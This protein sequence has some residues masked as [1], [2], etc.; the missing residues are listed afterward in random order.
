MVAFRCNQTLRRRI[1]QTAASE[2]VVPESSTRLGDWYANVV[3]VRRQHVVLAVS[4][5]TLLPVLVR[6][7]PYQTLLPRFAIAADQVLRALQID[8]GKVVAEADAMRDMVVARL[9]GG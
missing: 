7:A 8:E 5:V 1:G 6:A 3:S 9:V 4:G 2:V